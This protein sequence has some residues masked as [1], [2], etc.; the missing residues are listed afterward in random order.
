MKSIKQITRVVS[1]TITAHSPEILTGF[2]V[3]GMISSTILAV[4]ATPKA[5]RILE[6]MKNEEERESL[7]VKEVIKGTWKLYIPSVA[8]TV[9]SAG[10]VIV[11]LMMNKKSSAA[12]AAAYS[13]SEEALREYKEQV[14]QTLGEKKA[15][16]VNDGIAK[17]R[18]EN[19]PV[20]NKEVIIT[21]SGSS[22]CYD[23]VSKRYFESDIET[24]R[25]IAN[26]LNREMF[27]TMYVCLNDY[28]SQIGLEEV[29]VGDDVGWNVNKGLIEMS[30]S[31]Q[32]SADG[33][34]CLVV[35]FANP[36]FY[37]YDI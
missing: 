9:I 2:G 11:P 31:S 15:E 12:L 10:C 1:S 34:P 30:F 23:V 22:L 36:P 13:L 4:K 17:N 29:P 27:D 35:G 6:E 20:T 24:L 16:Q 37:N 19:D 28:Y 14:V 5:I 26:D 25:R 21:G 32:I 7:T 8:L 3:A 33:R 18:M